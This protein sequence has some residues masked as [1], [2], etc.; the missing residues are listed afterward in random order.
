MRPTIRGLTTL[1]GLLALTVATAR[2]APAQS[3]LPANA[4]APAAASSREL[5]A[6]QQVVHVLNR[7][8]FGARPGDVER[9]RALGVDAW[10][11]AQ[12]APEQIADPVADAFLRQFTALDLPAEVLIGRFPPPQLTLARTVIRRDAALSPADSA[13]LR[14]ELLEARRTTA[15]MVG[16]LHAAQVG[17][18]VASERQLNEV[19]VDFWTNHFSVFS[20]KGPLGRHHVIG[21]QR[22]AIRPHV[23]GRFRDMLGAV[24]QSPAMLAY[25]DNAQSR[26]DSGA[27]TLA[28]QRRPAMRA[29]RPAAAGRRP[30]GQS[31]PPQP[32]TVRPPG[33]APG[34]GRQPRMAQPPQMQQLLQRSRRGLNEN[35]ARELLELHTLGV[36]GGYSQQ[37]VIEVARA[38]TGWTLRPPAAGNGF[39]FRPEF[40][41]AGEKV[42][43]GTRIPAG[44]GIDDGEQ[45]LD[46]LARHPATA[47]FVAYKLAVRFVSDTPPDALV[48]RAAAT[49]LASDGDLRA[50]VRTIVTSP[51]FFASEAWRAKVKSPFE[52]VVSAARALGATPDPTPRTATMIATLGQPLYGHQAPNGWP[53][54][55]DA[56]IN[57]GSILSRINFGLAVAGGGVPGVSMRNWPRATTLAS[58]SRE[59]QVDGVVQALLGGDVSPDTRAVLLSGRNPFLDAAEPAGLPDA[60][61]DMPDATGVMPDA[62]AAMNGARAQAES[63][64]GGREPELRPAGG[65]RMGVGG[66]F[67][68]IRPLDGLAQVIG[69]ALGSPEF[70]R[71]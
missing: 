25:L 58:A 46:I 39:V 24:A 17:R 67:G 6:D 55:G 7:L 40:H 47:R 9:V 8:A 30:V 15:R 45:V 41:D 65:R 57:T 42:V 14:S 48:E 53:E 20:N 16:E 32:G 56:W 50:V 62:A 52:V 51:E 64:A 12:L 49:Y 26:A 63:M 2:S 33:A 28:D 23:F 54:T 35:Y 29:Q 61:N 59:V 60:T 44:G 37:D 10:I 19:L 36:D 69:L 4:P 34:T 68:R 70:Q 38:F 71:R 3:L 21:Y 1:A 43:L 31:R 5:T 66:G 22:D 18:A 27:P 13:R 11:E